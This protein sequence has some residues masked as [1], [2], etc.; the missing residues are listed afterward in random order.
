MF[1]P[2]TL[3]PSTASPFPAF[4][5]RPDTVPVIGVGFL[6]VVLFIFFLVVPKPALSNRKR[7]KSR[8]RIPEPRVKIPLILMHSVSILTPLLSGI[9]TMLLLLSLVWL[10]L[11]PHAGAAAGKKEEG[12]IKNFF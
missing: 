2:G 11:S 10:L 1:A 12:K 7:R 5:L 3:V 4:S 6:C 9:T 8:R